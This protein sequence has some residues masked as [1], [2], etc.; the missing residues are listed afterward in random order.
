MKQSV[1][2]LKILRRLVAFGLKIFTVQ[3]AQEAMCEFKLNPGLD[4]THKC[5]IIC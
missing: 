4:P 5:C 1:V 2:G 3:Q